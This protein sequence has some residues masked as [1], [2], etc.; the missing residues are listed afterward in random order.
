[1]LTKIIINDVEYI[2]LYSA[3]NNKEEVKFHTPLLK[4]LWKI[5][6][7]EENL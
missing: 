7:E 6:T 4:S 5:I 1:M 2:I 3:I